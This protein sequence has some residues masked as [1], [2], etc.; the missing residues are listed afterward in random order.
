MWLNGNSGIILLVRQY[1]GNSGIILLVRQYNCLFVVF[2][3]KLRLLPCTIL[4]SPPAALYYVLWCLNVLINCVLTC[5]YSLASFRARL[6]S[7]LMLTGALITEEVSPST[8]NAF[9]NSLGEKAVRAHLMK[10]KTNHHSLHQELP[11]AVKRWLPCKLSLDISSQFHKHRPWFE[12]AVTWMLSLSLRNGAYASMAAKYS[13]QC[14]RPPEMGFSHFLLAY[15]LK[16]NGPQ[17]HF[18]SRILHKRHFRQEKRRP[19]CPTILDRRTST[20][21]LQCLVVR[22]K[23]D[24]RLT[25]KFVVACPSVAQMRLM[26]SVKESDMPHSNWIYK[27]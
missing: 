17:R 27:Y 5:H 23:Q 18:S 16:V 22:Q 4:S 1:N 8:A 25:T 9:I 24:S 11:V 7:T 6:Y 2:I 19:V 26:V 12:H 3:W 10:K 15:F 21:I 20:W 13:W 14:K